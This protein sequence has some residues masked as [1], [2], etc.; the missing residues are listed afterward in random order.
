VTPS[1]ALRA[2]LASPSLAERHVVAVWLFGSRVRG[3]EGPGSDIDIGVLC[4]PP[5]GL[6]RTRVMDEVGRALGMDVDLVDMASAPPT[7]VWEIITTGRLIH[8][9]DEERVEGF[10]K[11]ARYA[12]EDAEQRHRMELLAY[13]GAVGGARR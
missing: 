11:R 1:D 6:E 13:A 10:V 9:I 5:L 2:L 7:L 8:E 3:T 4:D 12:D